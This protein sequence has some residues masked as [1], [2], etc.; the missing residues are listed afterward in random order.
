MPSTL[1]VSGGRHRRSPIALPTH[2]GAWHATKRSTPNTR[3]TLHPGTLL[4]PPSN[5]PKVGALSCS[6]LDEEVTFNDPDLGPLAP[7]PGAFLHLPLQSPNVGALRYSALGEEFNLG[8]PDSRPSTPT[9]PRTAPCF[10]RGGKAG[11]R[12]EESSLE[13][14]SSK[15]KMD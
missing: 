15:L 6:A 3:P 12:T 4:H 14:S 2:H 13:M 1:E 8:I 11:A 9:D 10:A 5:S 7:P